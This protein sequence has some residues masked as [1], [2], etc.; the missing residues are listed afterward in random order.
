M[1]W[2]CETEGSIAHYKDELGR[3]A[4]KNIDKQVYDVYIA[5]LS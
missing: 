4:L 5:T 1:E 2:S 3:R